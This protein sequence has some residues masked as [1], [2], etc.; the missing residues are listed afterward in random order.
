MNCPSIELVIVLTFRLIIPLSTLYCP[1]IELVIVLT[2]FL[3]LIQLVT[4]RSEEV[5]Y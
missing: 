3:Q 5:G 2:F 4:V 1:S